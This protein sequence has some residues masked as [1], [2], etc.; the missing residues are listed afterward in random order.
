MTRQPAIDVD[1]FLIMTF[2]AH[3]HTPLLGR[4]PLKVFY[5][6]VA[7]PAGNFAVDVALMIE[8]HVFGH[9]VHLDPGRG[10][11]GVE[12]FV[13]LLNPGMFFN[14][15]IVAVQTFFHRRNARKIGIGN[16]GMAVLAL[17]LLDATVHIV[18]EGDRLFRSES[19]PRPFPKNID[20]GGR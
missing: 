7:F 10:G 11:L 18:A 1:I 19:A 12:I 5:R 9:V 3:P 17:Y 4:K 14:N 13:L 16:V 8:Q 15:I 6:A 20:E 2:Q